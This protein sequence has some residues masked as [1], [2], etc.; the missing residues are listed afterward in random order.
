MKATK[1]IRSKPLLYTEEQHTNVQI[2]K[3]TNSM[4]ITPTKESVHLNGCKATQ[5]YYD[6]ENVTIVFGFDTHY[7][8]RFKTTWHPTMFAIE[9]KTIESI[10]VMQR[11]IDIARRDLIKTIS[12]REVVGDEKY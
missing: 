8:T 9:F 6:R 2:S 7:T 12:E 4:F 10:E 5:G 1:A 11:A 3:K